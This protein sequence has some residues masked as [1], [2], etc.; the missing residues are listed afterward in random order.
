MN[1]TQLECFLAVAEFLNFSRAAQTVQITQPAVTHQIHALEKE[2]GVPLFNRSSKNVEL[3]QAGLIFIP[4]AER[5]LQT[6]NSARSRLNE[7]SGESPVPL[8]IGCRNTLELKLLPP[9]LRQLSQEFPRLQPSIKLLPFHSID[10]L[11]QNG[12]IQLMFGFQ[13]PRRPKNKALGTFR[14]LAKCP[15]TCV[16][17]KTHPLAAYD[18]LTEAQLDGPL[19]LFKP[20]KEPHDVL[21][22]QNR[23]AGKRRHSQLLFGDGYET[24]M[25]LVRS[26]V[27]FCLF[28]KLPNVMEPDLRYLPVEGY[29]EIS[30]GVFYRSPITS[31]VVKRFLQLMKENF[32]IDAK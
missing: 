23:L 26:G 15:I 2:L 12:A 32:S 31:M 3:T 29:G 7:Q 24:V 19:I 13:D 20:N 27:G 4:D 5:I 21:L 14:E 11:M 25:T 6:A 16:C 18:H 9:A 28:P 30:F 8:D 1:T 10:N 22:L 17:S